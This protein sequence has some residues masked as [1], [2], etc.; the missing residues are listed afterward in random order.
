MNED[1]KKYYDEPHFETKTATPIESS[2][3]DNVAHLE[4]KIF[5]G[6]FCEH[7]RTAKPGNYKVMNLTREG[8]EETALLYVHENEWVNTY[9]E[10]IN[11]V[12]DDVE[13]D[14]FITADCGTY[15]ISYGKNDGT[16][17]ETCDIHQT[18]EYDSYFALYT[19]HNNTVFLL[20]DE[21]IVTGL[22]NQN[23]YKLNNLAND[24]DIELSRYANI[25]NIDIIDYAH[26]R[27]HN[28]TIEK[29]P[30]EPYHKAITRSIVGMIEKPSLS[31]ALNDLKETDLQR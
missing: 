18:N 6:E 23:F 24:T 15:G 19:N 16:Y 9:H 13:L 21:D 5:V 14:R 31:D 30:N 2:F 12:L 28:V 7:E 20:D 26:G 29:K 10:N 1:I 8:F 25:V 27:T 3:N 4:S 11:N 22:H 17:A